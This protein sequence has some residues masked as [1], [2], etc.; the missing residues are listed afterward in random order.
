MSDAPGW[1]R[2]AMAATY[3]ARVAEAFENAA[4]DI[5]TAEITLCLI[6]MAA[7]YRAATG[8][9]ANPSIDASGTATM[10]LAMAMEALQGGGLSDEIA[11]VAVFAE[12]LSGFGYSEGHPKVA[13]DEDW[14]NTTGSAMVTELTALAKY[15]KLN[16]GF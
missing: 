1:Q 16:G 13:A 3:L 12:V 9:L 10:Y 2:R 15:L 4:C 6:R 5:Q 11:A 8:L 7:P 14:I